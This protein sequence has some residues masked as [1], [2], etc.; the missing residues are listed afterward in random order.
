MKKKFWLTKMISAAVAAACAVNGILISNLATAADADVYE[1][2]DGTINAENRV[3][4]GTDKDGNAVTGASGGKFVWMEKNDGAETLSIKVNAEEAGMYAFTVSVYTPAGAKQQKLVINGVEQGNVA[5]EENANGFFDVPIGSYK[6]DKGE[7]TVSFVSSWGYMYF[8]CLKVTPAELPTLSANKVLSDGKATDETKRLMSYLV[9]VYGKNVISGQQE[10]Y[11]WGRTDSSG[12][13]TFEYDFDW[14]KENTGKYP[15]MR[16]FDFLNCANILYGSEDGTADR[17]ID[18]ANNKNGIVTASWHVTVPKQFANYTQGVTNVDWGNAT[19]KPDE[20][21]FDTSKAV[22]EGTKENKYYMACLEALA[23]QLKK[24]QDANVPV[25]FRPL[26]EAE[27]GGGETGSWFWWGKSGSDVYKKLW[28]LTYNT[29][30]ETYGLHNL[31][32]EWNSY[33]YAT[34]KDWYPGDEYVDIIGYDKYNC[35]DW[36]TGSPILKHNDSAIGG[37]FYNLVD[38]FEGK[39]VAM[40]ENDNVPTLAN[41]TAE[42]A[43]WLTFCTWYDGPNND[44]EKFLTNPVF[45]KL[46]DL[47]ELY[48]SDYCITL[49]EMPADIY[50]TYSMEGFGE[51]PEKP[52]EPV[53]TAVTTEVTTAL[54]TSPSTATMTTMTTTTPTT[55]P[56][57]VQTTTQPT[58]TEIPTTPVPVQTTTQP[59]T[60]GN[61][62]TLPEYTGDKSLL[63]YGD[64][65]LD[66]EITP[67]DIVQIVK[68]IISPDIYPLGNGTDASKAKALEQSDVEHDRYINEKDSGKIKEAILK[69]ILFESLGK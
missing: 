27:G 64:V 53:T 65:N 1:F 54:Q 41:L 63:K 38:M 22:V 45:N 24:L 57:P 44:S 28:K 21:D 52:T 34:S 8:D 16:G 30:T 26:H 42:K 11:M 48:N 69:H 33:T 58:T 46:E 68:Y 19:Y 47:K 20:T 49:D 7:N 60:T 23:K 32:W 51:S 61:P 35:T 9:D 18:W 13:P 17:M 36:S 59:T 3:Y 37:T 5:F 40:A 29:L 56:V 67:S 39:M 43:A 6:L 4:E 14:L 25:I 50:K 12:Q 55:T 31:I 62:T 15:A 66:N 2:E 10:I